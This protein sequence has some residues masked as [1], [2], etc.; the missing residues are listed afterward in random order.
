MQTQGASHSS[1]PLPT[2][3]PSDTSGFHCPLAGNFWPFGEVVRFG[4]KKGMVG[5]IDYKL[6]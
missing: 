5:K 4:S 2:S 3:I 1:Y 6:N